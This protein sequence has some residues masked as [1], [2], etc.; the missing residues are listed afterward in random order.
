MFY[1]AGLLVEGL[2]RLSGAASEVDEL[3]SKFDQPPTYGKYLSLGKHDVHAI[4]GLVKKYLRLYLIQLS[5]LLT[6]INFCRFQVSA[7]LDMR[8]IQIQKW[9]LL[10]SNQS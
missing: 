4:T 1:L 3:Q 10:Q 6:M 8:V 5:Q 2:F 7:Y 9:Y